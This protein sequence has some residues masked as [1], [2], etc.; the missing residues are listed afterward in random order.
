MFTTLIE[1]KHKA[2]RSAAGTAFSVVLHALLIT[3]AV[4]VT[5]HA[6]T[7]M[8][9]RE[10]AEHVA[11][12]KPPKPKAPPP[13]QPAKPPPPQ[14]VAAP[15]PPKGFQ[16]LVAPIKIP[17]KIPQVD[18]SKAVTNA[19]DF[20]GK[21]VEGG[22][23]NGVA[24]GTPSSTH[25]YFAFQV[26]KQ[27]LARHA[28]VPA[29]AYPATLRDAGV[30]GQVMLQF[31]VDTLGKIDMST[32]KV[33]KSDNDLFSDAVKRLAPRWTFYPAEAGGHKVRQI[34]QLPIQF[35]PPK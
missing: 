9:K 23:A 5:A 20:S 3:L 16:T 28:G 19:A 15:P 13:Q 21:G 12:V 35:V 30:G 24:G 10:K 18:L 1:S 6:G 32:F 29:S 31:V 25:N 22:R 14:A 34:V 4:W 2:D 17:T 26:D 7:E 33:L 11:F 8:V 27:A